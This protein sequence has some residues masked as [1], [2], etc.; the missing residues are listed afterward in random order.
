MV[1]FF[2]DRIK[3]VLLFINVGLDFVGFLYLKDSDEKVYIC[4]FICVVICVVYLEL[5]CDMMIE[6]FFFVLRCMIVRRGMCSIIWLD[7]VKIFKVVN[8]EL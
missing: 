4:L 5:V 7:N 6:W 1:L 8:K 3:F 2:E